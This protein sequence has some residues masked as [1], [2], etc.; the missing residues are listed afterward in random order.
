MKKIRTLLVAG[1]C[2]I[3][4][5]SFAACK[6]YDD[7]GKTDGATATTGSSSTDN[8]N[9]S[10]GATDTSGSNGTTDSETSEN[11]VLV[12]YFSC[13]NTTKRVAETIRGE[14]D[15][16]DIYRITPAIQYTAADLNYNSDCRANREQNDPSARPAISG[17]LENM[18]QYKVIFLGYPIWWGQA[19]KIIY[20]FLES[21]GFGFEGVTIIPFCT[22]GSS[23]IGSSATNLHN[24]APSANWKSGARISGNNIQSVIS[25]MN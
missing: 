4:A 25:Q 23:G 15:G 3:A 6:D 14:I 24:S 11:K 5:F 18:E 1:L 17:K 2:L 9:S 16:S 19:P 21:Y 13:T 22:S 20:T 12:V 8:T 7:N 10:A